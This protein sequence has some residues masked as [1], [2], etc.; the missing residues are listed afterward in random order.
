[1]G[2][3]TAI[4]NFFTKK[5]KLKLFRRFFFFIWATFIDYDLLTIFF[6][7]IYFKKIIPQTFSIKSIIDD[8]RDVKKVKFHFNRYL[9]CK[10]QETF[11]LYFFI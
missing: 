7:L 11:I 5:K 8:F 2:K 1:M 9:Q 4:F 3:L 10:Y 6:K